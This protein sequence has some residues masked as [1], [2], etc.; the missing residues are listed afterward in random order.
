MTVLFSFY[1]AIDGKFNYSRVFKAVVVDNF[2]GDVVC[3][4]FER[5]G[6][7]PLLVHDYSGVEFVFCGIVIKIPTVKFDACVT[8]LRKLETLTINNLVIKYLYCLLFGFIRFITLLI[9]FKCKSV[10]FVLYRRIFQQWK[11]YL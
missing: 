6:L 7:F 11:R 1:F 4:R 2:N 3:S 8:I 5:N 10:Y 9:R